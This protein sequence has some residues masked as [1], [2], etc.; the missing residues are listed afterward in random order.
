MRQIQERRQAAAKS[1][2]RRNMNIY[3]AAS[4]F[5]VLILLYI[6]I[7][8][9]FTLLFRLIGLPEEKARFQVVSL[10][11]GSGFTTRES[12]MIISTRRR[13]RLARI[14]MLFGYVFN[15][16]V[17]SAFIN[18]FMSLKITQVGQ[19]LLGLLI[20]VGMVAILIIILRIPAVRSFGSALVLKAVGNI[21][22]TKTAN[23]VM[24]IDH[25]GNGTIAQ[26]HIMAVPEALSGK[27]LFESKL[28]EEH[29]IL[30]MLVE[31]KHGKVE[32]PHKDTV[33]SEGEKLT[34]F[35]DYQNICRVFEAREHFE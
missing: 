30:I 5:A 13:R 18:V 27:R 33:F 12:E 34:V 29:N 20:P 10:L 25:I 21:T 16:S 26:V 31:D 3:A 8:E 28:K 1:R 11:T 19:Y 23:T 22:H 15:I 2:P 9:V 35:G 14:T 32:A 17:V 6:I 24:I 4:L 7:S